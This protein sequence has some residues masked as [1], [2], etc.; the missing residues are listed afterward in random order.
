MSQLKLRIK[1]D[2]QDDFSIL[3]PLE[4]PAPLVRPEGTV[5]Y[6]NIHTAVARN[7]DGTREDLNIL[8]DT[9]YSTSGPNDVLH[10]YN[11]GKDHGWNVESTQIQSVFPHTADVY[12]SNSVSSMVDLK[13]GS[14]HIAALTRIGTNENGSPRNFLFYLNPNSRYKVWKSIQLPEEDSNTR[15]LLVKLGLDDQSR[16]CV[17]YCVTCTET[18]PAHGGK[19]TPALPASQALSVVKELALSKLRNVLVYDWN[20]ANYPDPAVDASL[21]IHTGFFTAA[22]PDLA[23]TKLWRHTIGADQAVKVTNAIVLRFQIVPTLGTSA[24]LIFGLVR[25]PTDGEVPLLRI[26]FI[27]NSHYLPNDVDDNTVP[28]FSD[29]PPTWIPKSFRAVVSKVSGLNADGTPEVFKIDVL[30]LFELPDKSYELWHTYN[31]RGGIK[32]VSDGVFR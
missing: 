4:L 13:T 24:P 3:E 28:L 8:C 21:N 7:T 10:F 14:L 27:T 12:T 6:P 29:V 16:V 26:M 25:A 20:M 23:P 15:P 9:G 1:T 32:E 5:V 2:F 30:G 22:A 18:V 31:L 17:Y 11:S 19:W